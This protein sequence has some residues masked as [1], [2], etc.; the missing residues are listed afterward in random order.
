MQTGDLVV[1]DWGDL[2]IITSQV[3]VTDRWRLKY[4]ITGAISV[5]WGSSLYPLRSKTDRPT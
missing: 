2:A 4:I 5:A 3:G 1:D